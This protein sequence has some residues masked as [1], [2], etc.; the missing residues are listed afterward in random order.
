MKLSAVSKAWRRAILQTGT[1]RKRINQLESKSE[2]SRYFNSGDDVTVFCYLKL[3]EKSGVVY[4]WGLDLEGSLTDQL[5]DD[6]Q[7]LPTEI[8]KFGTVTDIIAS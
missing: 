2:N 1:V 5:E 8:T 6:N 4:G 7:T 3:L